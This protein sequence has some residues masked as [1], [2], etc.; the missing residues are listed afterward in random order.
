MDSKEDQSLGLNTKRSYTGLKHFL[1]LTSDLRSFK[2]SVMCPP[3]VSVLSS[4]TPVLLAMDLWCFLTF[5]DPGKQVSE[6][7]ARIGFCG[8]I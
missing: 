6:G 3:A 2:Q 1:H 8:K 4:L 5:P 7:L